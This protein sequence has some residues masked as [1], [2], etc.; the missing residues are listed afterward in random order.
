[1]PTFLGLRSKPAATDQSSDG[2]AFP[3]GDALPGRLQTSTWHST[4]ERR[5]EL[6]GNLYLVEMDTELLK[7]QRRGLIKYVRYV[8]DIKVFAKDYKIARAVIFM[9]NRILRSLHLNMQSAKTE[10]YEGEDV[11]K[12]LHD[13]HVDH[14]TEIIDSLPGDSSKITLEQKKEA[15]T[16]VRPLF[17]KRLVYKREMQKEDL[18]LFKRI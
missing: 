10:V 3:L 8:D 1:M 12:R 13:E 6:A 16:A 14:V 5:L 17:R 7:L 11:R 9:I 18:R 4:G 2:D 15:I